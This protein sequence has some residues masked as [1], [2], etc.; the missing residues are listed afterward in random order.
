MFSFAVLDDLYLKNKDLPR[1]NDL[2][3]LV[4]ESTI[5]LAK[6]IYMYL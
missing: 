4:K 2:V 6:N 5:F 3:K 1:I